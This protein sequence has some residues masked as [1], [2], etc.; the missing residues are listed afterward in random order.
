MVPRREEPG[1]AES[2][3]AVPVPGARSRGVSTA[4]SVLRLL[5]LLAHAADGMRADEVAEALG[6][7]TSTAYN[8][9][10][11][12]C[13]EGFTVRARGGAYHLTSEASGSSPP[14]RAREVARRPRRHCSTSSSSARTS[15]STSRRRTP[16][17]SSSR[18]P[19]AVRACRRMPGL[20]TRI[21][22]NAHALALG[23]VAL[24]LLDAAALDR[25]IGRGLRPFTPHTIVS[26]DQLRAQL[27]DIRAGEV[28]FDREEFDEDFC[29]LAK[30]VVD[31]RG[32][33]VAALGLSMSSRCFDTER[34]ALAE[35]LTD[36]ACKA[37]EV[38]SSPRGS[39]D[40]GR[41]R[42]FLSARRSPAN[43]QTAPL[44]SHP[45]RQGRKPHHEQS[46]H[47]EG[48]QQ[49]PGAVLGPDLRG[50]GRQVPDR[51]HVREGSEE[52]SAQAGPALVLPDGGG[53]GQPRLRRDG[54]RHP[55]QH[56][57]PG[58]GAL[59][60]VA[61][62]LPLDHP[63]PRDLRR[64]GDAAGHQRGPEPR[65]PQRPGHPDDR[66][67]PSLDDPDEPQ[68]A[69]H[70]PLHRP[71]R[72][73]HHREGV[74][75]L[76][77]GD[78]RPAVRRGVHHRRRHHG[79]QRLPDDRR[80]DRVHQRALRRDARRGGGQRR[81]P[82]AD[83]LP[84]GAV[85]RVA[86]HL[87]RLLDHPHGA[88]RRAQPGAARARPALRLVEQPRGRGR[89]HRHVH[90]VRHEGPP[91]GPRQLRRVVAPLD[92][93]RLLPQLPGP[94]GEVRP[95]D[96][97]RPRRGGVGPHLEQ[98]LHPRGRAVLRHRLVRQLL[99]DRRDGRHRL[100]VVR[101]QVPG[102]VRQVRQVVG[103]LRATSRRR[104]A[105]SRSPSS[106]GS[107]TTSTRT[108]AGRAWCRA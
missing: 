24:S 57:P 48:S 16:G 3:H 40:L 39:S 78:D 15:A 107:P 2:L 13:Q 7:S 14:D 90:R 12:L 58:P 1:I 32:R 99:A 18:S 17:R 28:A 10:D 92:L 26:P 60:G 63:V 8:L 44:C 72:V 79:G 97:A 83:G 35:V 23:K 73:R 61:E 69:V 43:V 22:A 25:Y 89:R 47:H 52:G 49:D 41:H 75:E 6:K 56:V 20:G 11:T 80:G 5:A 67:G 59:D 55:R 87:Q 45:F 53:E 108:A 91:Q 4:R 86:P 95:D 84:L 70:E 106:P 76:L 38:L 94:A 103:A 51:L 19:A 93:R 104:T 33:A 105:T 74:L 82:A 102:L 46:Q 54:R 68:A 66:R 77:R 37:S 65:G 29:C 62:A 31:A 101:A 64:A 9:L 42:T 88:R 36:V 34:E 81:L 30:P 96:P 85:R 21:G 100:R 50:A 71:G 98:G 27:D